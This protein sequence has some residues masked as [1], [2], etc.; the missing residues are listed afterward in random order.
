MTPS[1][2]ANE[3]ESVV[4]VEFEVCDP[5]YP[6]VSI[7]EQLGCRARV[8]Q[9]VPRPNHAYAIFY[10]VVGA[11][12]A[13]VL[14]LLEG[15]EGIEAHVVSSGADG[16]VVE[17]RV[18]NP[19]EHFV[20]ALTEAGAIPTD[21]RSE[22]GVA[23][24][25]AEVPAVYSVQ[26]VVETFTTAHPSVEVV[27]QRQKQHA[28]PLFTR[29][30]FQRALD[31][32]LTPRQREVMLAAYVGGYYD[33]PRGKSGEEVAAELDISLPTFSQHLREAERKL[34]SLVFGECDAR[35]HA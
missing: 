24:I 4:E 3:T 34:M 9:I 1:D 20:V 19:E 25:V 11:N 7:P 15:S 26:E 31:D 23:R 6:L 18:E 29:R 16:G 28:V 14:P 33:W 8:E 12:P 32:L 10:S 30:E 27:A 35:Q 22:G 5:A 21:L 13:D 17:V 2:P